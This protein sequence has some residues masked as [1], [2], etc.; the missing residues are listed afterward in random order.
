MKNVKVQEQ[1]LNEISKNIRMTGFWGWFCVSGYADYRFQVGIKLSEIKGFEETRKHYE[2][3]VEKLN[4]EKCLHIIHS[5]WSDAYTKGEQPSGWNCIKLPKSQE[6]DTLRVNI[7]SIKAQ[8]ESAG[9]KVESISREGYFDYEED[10]KKQF[11]PALCFHI[12][13]KK[14]DEWRDQQYQ[15]NF[16]EGVIECEWERRREMEYTEYQFCL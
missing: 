11:A 6:Y 9:Y 15:A 5:L 16:H 1:M 3:D 4:G 13:S 12:S 8:I 14:L 2:A 7:L 10:G